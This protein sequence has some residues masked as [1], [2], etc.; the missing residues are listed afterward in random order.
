MIGELYVNQADAI[1]KTTN[2]QPPPPQTGEFTKQNWLLL[3]T[4]LMLT[5]NLKLLFYA[6]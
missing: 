5:P 3:Y 4:L 1:T 6:L 2:K